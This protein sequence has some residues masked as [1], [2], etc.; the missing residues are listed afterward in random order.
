[1]TAI[2]GILNKVGVAIAADSAVTVTSP[3]GRKIYNQAK[4]IFTLSKVHPIGIMIYNAASLM[5][6]PW[7]I[8]IKLYREQLK[9]NSFEK[10]EDYVYD[11]IAF[12]KANDYFCNNEM[13]KMYFQSFLASI[14]NDIFN[15]YLSNIE[16]NIETWTEEDKINFQKVLLNE[17]AQIIINLNQNINNSICPDFKNFSIEDFKTS[18]LFEV[19][20]HY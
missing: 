19:I 11:F 2:V 14:I 15:K 3:S 5:S 8:I 17:V 4:K 20:N 16:R 12:L 1:M 6:T 10:T 18:S 7:E 9:E 13:Q